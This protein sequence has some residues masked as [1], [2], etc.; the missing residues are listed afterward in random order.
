MIGGDLALD[1]ME[2]Q[3]RSFRIADTSH[4]DQMQDLLRKYETLIQDYRRLRSDFEEEREGRERYKK[5]ARGH[6]KNPFALVLIDGDGYLFTEELI[7]AGP[8][9]GAHAAHSLRAELARVVA[10]IGHLD[11]VE[12][13][14]RIYCNVDGLYGK[15]GDSAAQITPFISAFNGAEPF[16]EFVDV[17]DG[18]PES[19]TRKVEETFFLFA[20]STQCRHIL[21]A[22]CH[23]ARYLPLLEPHT[24][25]SDRV[26]LLTAGKCAPEYQALELASIELDPIFRGGISLP[27]LNGNGMAI[28]GA[29]T[30]RT[31][32]SSSP[33]RPSVTVAPPAISSTAITSTTTSVAG[34][35]TERDPRQGVCTRFMQKG[36][37]KFGNKCKYAHPR[38][39]S[40]ADGN[41][42][43]FAGD[44]G[45]S[46]PA[47]TAADNKYATWIPT[48]APESRLAKKPQRKTAQSAFANDWNNGSQPAFADDWSSAPTNSQPTFA[49]DWEAAAPIK[50]KAHQK[51]GSSND[52]SGTT[53]NPSSPSSWA[54]DWDSTPRAGRG[55]PTMGLQTSSWAPQV[56]TVQLKPADEELPAN[57][58]FATAAHLPRPSPE[59]EGLIAVNKDGHRLDF[60]IPRPTHIEMQQY[61]DSVTARSGKKH[62]NEFQLRGTCSNTNAGKEC[63]YDHSPLKQEFF[64]ILKYIVSTRPCSHGAECRIGPC[65]Y[66]HIC[67]RPNCDNSKVCRFKRQQH[68][69][70]LDIKVA[71]WVKPSPENDE[72]PLLWMDEDI[73]ALYSDTNEWKPNAEWEPQSADEQN[74]ANGEDANGGSLDSDQEEAPEKEVIQLGAEEEMTTKEDFDI[75][76]DDVS[77]M[78]NNE[79][80]I[81]LGEP[82]EEPSP[83]DSLAPE[84]EG[85]TTAAAAPID[86]NADWDQPGDDAGAAAQPDFADEWGKAGDAP[87]DFADD[88]GTSNN[89]NSSQRNQRNATMGGAERRRQSPPGPAW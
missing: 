45:N 68:P 3:V 61:H 88:W 82:V 60:Y 86:F 51:T 64:H 58:A 66:G 21:F 26:T 20:E 42:N 32:S 9:G 8:D 50:P 47:S 41:A 53:H 48:K 7:A 63:K 18:T 55:K 44:L 14:V 76:A 36:S 85:D 12:L 19:A 6:E 57:G 11:H 70:Q 75:G 38:R 23:D 43:S 39:D 65:F 89:N 46:A 71:K 67:Q 31:Q 17:Y 15:L 79:E 27:A 83:V 54:Q 72:E 49:G 69:S 34:D 29:A 77:P 78:G 22:G 56:N 74:G 37:C 2:H 84:V 87:P 80:L 40:A 59:T 35:P 28:K 24:G 25:R 4:H 13:L 73:D 62:C 16:F 33:S 30:R 1:A 10:K 52:L 5:Q 81:K